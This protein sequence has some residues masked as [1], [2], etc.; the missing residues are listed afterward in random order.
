M[1]PPNPPVTAWPLLNHDFSF[2]WTNAFQKAF[3]QDISFDITDNVIELY[4]NGMS[5]DTLFLHYSGARLDGEQALLYLRGGSSL[6]ISGTLLKTDNQPGFIPYISTLHLETTSSFPLN[7]LMLQASVNGNPYTT[8]S[9]FSVTQIN[10]IFRYSANVRLSNV[11]LRLSVPE[12]VSTE[13]PLSLLQAFSDGLPDDAVLLI[14][15]NFQSYSDIDAFPDLYILDNVVYDPQGNNHHKDNS[16]VWGLTQGFIALFPENG[17]GSIT[18]GPFES[19][20][21]AEMWFSSNGM[22]GN[23]EIWYR[24]STHQEFR[25]ASKIIMNQYAG[26]GKYLRIRFPETP[27]EVTFQI[28]AGHA[29]QHTKLH[30]F[31]LWK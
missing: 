4:Y 25:L 16:L 10:D 20:R 3:G 9:P 5:A 8:L 18:F 30:G 2:M 31:R 11:T 13:F 19:V 21:L 7:T 29:S 26:I 6:E 27:K 28:R 23:H 17:T 14:E 12:D 15:E 1:L 24:T 22:Q